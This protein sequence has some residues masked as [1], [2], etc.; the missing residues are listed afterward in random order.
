M[1]SSRVL[2]ARFVRKAQTAPHFHLYALAGGPPAR[3]GL[4]R[5]NDGAAIAIE[6]WAVPKSRFGD[7]IVGVPHPLGIGTLTLDTGEAVKGFICEAVGLD[8]AMDV[9][10]YGGWRNYLAR[11]KT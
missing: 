5:A 7:F 3:P 8:G 9:T 2:G 11:G 1:A 6:I 4:V 10:Q